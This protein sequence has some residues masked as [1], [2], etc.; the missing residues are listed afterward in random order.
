M[1][2]KALIVGT[3]MLLAGTAAIPAV[4]AAQDA[5][6]TAP[7]TDAA[8]MPKK[9]RPVPFRAAVMF[10]ILDTN[11]DGSV[12]AEEVLVLQTAMFNALDADGSGSLSEQELA[13]MMRG[14]G[15]KGGKA[16]RGHGDGDGPRGQQMGRGSGDGPKGG[17]FRRGPGGRDGGRDYGEHRDGPRH[18]HH[19]DGQTAERRGPPRD[20]DGAMQQSGVDQNRAAGRGA[21]IFA[22]ADANGDG[23]VTIEEFQVVTAKLQ[24]QWLPN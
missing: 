21:Q 16:G 6:E 1:T 23:V 5:T 8:T 4:S 17:E 9:D 10:N 15:P 14:F 12:S 11:G 7:T 2:S 18:K 19:R 13:K 22:E 24:Q 3:A 20:R